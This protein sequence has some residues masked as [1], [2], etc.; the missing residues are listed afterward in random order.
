MSIEWM[1][2]QFWTCVVHVKISHF[3]F[4]NTSLLLK[5]MELHTNSQH[6]GNHSGWPHAWV[7][8]IFFKM[9][10]AFNQ[11]PHISQIHDLVISFFLTCLIWIYHL[12]N[13]RHDCIHKIHKHL[14]GD[15]TVSIFKW[16]RHFCLPNRCLN[17]WVWFQILSLGTNTMCTW[18]CSAK[19]S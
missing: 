15:E 7:M 19:K 17:A 9:P 8:H 10:V 1:F 18:R 11:G 2:S 4:V 13:K 5:W 16:K 6:F 12:S 14:L 3:I